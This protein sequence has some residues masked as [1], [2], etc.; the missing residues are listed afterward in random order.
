MTRSISATTAMAGLLFASGAV[1]QQPIDQNAQ[2]P[3]PTPPPPDQNPAGPTT[4]P[5]TMPRLEAEVG[6]SREQLTPMVKRALLALVIFFHVGGGWALTQV[7][8]AKL[9]VGD[10]APMTWPHDSRSQ[11]L[12]NARR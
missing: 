7:E 10:I 2:G 6:A 8:P 11:R 9:I 5:A 1:A 3:A 12:T 4:A